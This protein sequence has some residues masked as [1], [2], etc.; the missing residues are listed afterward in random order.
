MAIVSK[1]CE[2]CGQAH[3]VRRADLK[4]GK[5]RFCSQSCLYNYRREQSQRVQLTCDHCGRSFSKLASQAKWTSGSFCQR[6]CYELSQRRREDRQCENC[7]AP[8]EA[9]AS[10]IRRGGGRFCSLAC[11]FEWN[12]GANHSNWTG[13]EAQ[14]TRRNKKPGQHSTA[15][16]RRL[17]DRQRGECVY[18]GTDLSGGFHR[19]HIIPLVLGG[20]HFVGNI[21]L[22]CPDCNVQKNAKLPIVFRRQVGM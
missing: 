6:R 7:G 1:L 5:G 20:T 18:C 2:Q 3:E 13:G 14:H 16:I 8:F 12:T 22:T 21:Q 15:D 10:A 11:F 19:D 4:R 9:K 17:Y